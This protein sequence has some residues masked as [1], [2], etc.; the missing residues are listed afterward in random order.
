MSTDENWAIITAHTTATG[1]GGGG[2]G[3]SGS[4]SGQIRNR[5]SLDRTISATS[6]LL[7]SSSPLG[8]RKSFKFA[9]FKRKRTKSND[10]NS[11]TLDGHRGD[12]YHSHHNQSSTLSSYSHANQ[13]SSMVVKDDEIA[14]FQRELQNIPR[15]DTPPLPITGSGSPFFSSPLSNYLHE[16]MERSLSVNNG[17]Q[18]SCSVPRVSYENGSLHIPGLQHHRG[19]S[20]AAA[21]F[22]G[23]SALPK[24]N[25]SS[26]SGD[27]NTSIANQSA[28]NRSPASLSPSSEFCVDCLEHS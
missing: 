9:N 17:R 10:N 28:C 11:P 7:G 19:S 27:Q 25:N 15:N 24:P 20:P 16:A 1:S 14:S 2:S 18:R 3:G 21:I 22:Q 4:G 6:D 12:L 8:G 23:L 26:I 5:V 13:V